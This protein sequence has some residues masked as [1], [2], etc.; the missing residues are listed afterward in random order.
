ML[1]IE[2]L[3]IFTDNLSTEKKGYRQI[4]INMNNS[5]ILFKIVHFECEGVFLEYNLIFCMN[6]PNIHQ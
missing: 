4:Y 1:L 5:D 2:K 6:L 3:N